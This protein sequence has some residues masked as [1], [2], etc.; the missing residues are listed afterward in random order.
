MMMCVCL[1]CRLHG[2]LPVI[3]GVGDKNRADQTCSDEILGGRARM[4][5]RRMKV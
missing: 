5:K 3:D 2:S 1:V 4:S